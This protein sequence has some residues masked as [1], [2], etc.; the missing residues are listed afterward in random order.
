MQAAVGLAQL[1]KLPQFVE[2]RKENF[3]KLKAGLKR[4]EKYLLLPEATP[5]SDPAWFGFPI[6]VRTNEWFGQKDIVKYLEQNKI[7]TRQLFAGNITRQPAYQD[8]ACRIVGEL[9]NTDDI[10]NNTFF[11]GVYP[12]IDERKMEYILSQ[13]ANFFVLYSLDK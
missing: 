5:K 4:W 9:A 13:F 10:M 11:I 1:K 3:R 7:L 12:G 2:K 8:I 6:T